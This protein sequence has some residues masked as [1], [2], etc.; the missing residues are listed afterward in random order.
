MEPE[1]NTE[2]QDQV[3]DKISQEFKITLP[4]Q[5]LPTPVRV[6]AFFTLIGGFSI[7]GSLFVDIVR[8][9][10]EGLSFFILRTIAGLTAISIA[11]GIIEHKRWSIWLYGAFTLFAIFSNLI[12]S[13]IPLSVVIYLYIKRDFFTP[14]PPD[15]LLAKG[16]N[17]IKSRLGVKDPPIEQ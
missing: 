11:Y 7:I 3:A 12:L 15:I 13:I 6:I 16:V 1:E 4:G 9:L 8:P 10:E 17:Y 2:E 14:S 5:N